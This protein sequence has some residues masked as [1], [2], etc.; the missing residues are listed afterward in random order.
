MQEKQITRTVL[1]N[2]EGENM[3]SYLRSFALVG[4]SLLLISGMVA[5]Y[6]MNIS[7]NSQAI[8]T[9][10]NGL[11]SSTSIMVGFSGTL[12]GLILRGIDRKRGLTYWMRCVIAFAVVGLMMSAGQLYVAFLNL[13]MSNYVDAI[14]NGL[15]GL[16]LSLCIFFGLAVII[17]EKMIGGVVLS[18]DSLHEPKSEKDFVKS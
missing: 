13:A 17:V 12:I 11:A 8:P 7:L 14:R 3:R 4:L 1:S 2:N 5:I 18:D 16:L 6:V 10:I 15:M 9:V